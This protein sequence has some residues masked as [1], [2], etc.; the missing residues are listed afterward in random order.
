M[1]KRLTIFLASSICVGCS[2]STTLPASNKSVSASSNTNAASSDKGGHTAESQYNA[3]PTSAENNNGG[4]FIA[5]IGGAI[6]APFVWI[7]DQFDKSSGHTPAAAV[8]KMEDPAFADTRRQG[9]IDLVT[10]WPYTKKAPYTTRY[11]QIAKDDPDYT[12][13]AM[14]IRSLNISR[15]KLAVPVFIDA[16]ND[17][18]DLVRLE[19]VKALNNIPDEKAIPAL[20]KILSGRRESMF[21]GR[22]ES[23]DENHDVRIAA[24]EALRNYR[25]KDVAR[26]LINMLDD[27]DFAIAWQSHESLLLITGVD[28]RFDEGAWLK[29]L[30]EPNNTLG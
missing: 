18:N 19:A 8:K 3:S 22:P 11:A 4:S 16:L 24:A 21:E 15:D 26:S 1:H 10:S 5:A 7:G 17:D 12:V 30:G 9:M 2:Q 27:R 6:A 25:K 13:R 14:A 23:V 20:L 28:L 29:W